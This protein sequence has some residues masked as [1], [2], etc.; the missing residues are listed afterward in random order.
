MMKIILLI[1]VLGVA[2]AMYVSPSFYLRK[3]VGHSTQFDVTGYLGSPFHSSNNPDGSSEWTYQTEKIPK[4]CVEYVLTFKPQTV[5][6]DPSQPV[7]TNKKI[8]R[9][10]DWRWC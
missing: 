1:V 10:W 7:L 5:S 9:K 3:G 2:V 4:V 6:E 8:L